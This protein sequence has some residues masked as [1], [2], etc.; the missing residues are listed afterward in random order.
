MFPDMT[1]QE[2][3]DWFASQAIPEAMRILWSEEGEGLSTDQRIGTAVKFAY[4]IAGE[5]LVERLAA[6]SRLGESEEDVFQ[7]EPSSTKNLRVQCVV[8]DVSMEND[9]GREVEGIVA[10]CT[11]CD[12]RTESYGSGPA[13][14][15]RCLAL[16]RVECPRGEINFYD[17]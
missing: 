11:R 9:R 13:S 1:D 2:R 7:P 4:G 3:L 6:I 8:S 17:N 15:R 5:M 14:V 12:H 10:V 16:M